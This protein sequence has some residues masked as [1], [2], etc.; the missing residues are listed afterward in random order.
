MYRIRTLFQN[1][2]THLSLLTL[3]LLCFLAMIS[4]AISSVDATNTAEKQAALEESIMRSALHC[5]SLE[6]AYPSSITYLEEN[7]NLTIDRDT[8]IVH[9]EIFAS[10]IAPDITVILKTE[11]N[12]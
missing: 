1:M 12:G 2:R 11:T 7:Y 3:V 5:Y 9:Y 8:Y 10:N 6:G 4:V